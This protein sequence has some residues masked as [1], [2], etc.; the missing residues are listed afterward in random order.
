VIF[1]AVVIAW[2]SIQRLDT[3]GS[4]TGMASG[5]RLSPSRVL[6]WNQSMRKPRETG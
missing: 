5:L 6:A 3:V 4:V 1:L 2:S